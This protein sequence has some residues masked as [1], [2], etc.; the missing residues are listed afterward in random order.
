[1]LRYD[2]EQ[3]R[4]IMVPLDQKFHDEY[5]NILTGRVFCAVIHSGGAG[6]GSLLEFM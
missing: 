2:S 1:M 5:N 6:L 4:D 3:H